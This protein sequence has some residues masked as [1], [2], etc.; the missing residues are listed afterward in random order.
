M[1]KHNKKLYDTIAYL[2][3]NLTKNRLMKE[4]YCHYNR[5]VLVILLMLYSSIPLWP[6]L[7]KKYV[8]LLRSL[9]WLGEFICFTYK[10]HYQSEMYMWLIIFLS[11]PYIFIMFVVANSTTIQ[12]YCH[13]TLCRMVIFSDRFQNCPRSA[14][15]VFTNRYPHYKPETIRRLRFIMGIPIPIRRRLLSK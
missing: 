1:I 5:R 7:L 12:V 3:P 9:L 11:F 14:G 2:C 13:V 8:L 4:P 15:P 10:N 6:Q